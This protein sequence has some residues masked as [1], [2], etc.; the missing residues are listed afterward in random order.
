MRSRRSHRCAGLAAIVVLLALLGAGCGGGSASK[1]HAATRAEAVTASLRSAGWQ[2]RAV[3]G[4]PHTITG[5]PQLSYLQATA[6]S[7]TQIDLQLFATAAQARAEAAAAIAK[8]HG[9]RATALDDLI[10]FSRGDGHR[11][12]TTTDLSALRA[13]LR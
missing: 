9:F 3:A 1:P 10:A 4:M 13:A 6:P 2:V 5:A 12:L 11:R 7:G 8:L